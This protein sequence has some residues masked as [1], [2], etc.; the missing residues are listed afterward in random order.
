MKIAVTGANSNV[1]INFLTEISSNESIQITAGVRSKSAIKLLPES[2][3]IHPTIIDYNDSASLEKGI[4]GVDCVV[5]L[6]GI[7]I[8]GKHTKYQQANVDATAA[9]VAAVKT[10]N[11]A[12]LIFI[13]VIGADQNSKNEYF[14]SKGLA[15]KAIQDSNLSA[16]I[17]RT[18]I[19]L[20]PNTAGGSSLL[21][22]ARPEK[23]K[24]LGGGYYKM[25]PLDID[26]LNTAIINC[27]E[28]SLPGCKT[29]ELVGPEAISYRDLVSRVASMQGHAVKI[30]TIPIG[31]T[32]LMAK[33]TSFIK[34]G[35]F[36]P[37]VIDVITQDEEVAQN[38]DVE[39]GLN[40]TSLET[41]L[42]KLLEQ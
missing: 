39:L 28:K 33:L 21:N 11:L 22:T 27:A 8:E 9:V 25:R 42:K 3:N 36:T 5:H 12:H 26:D 17:L 20:G 7:L 30:G 14:R 19:L 24:L 1:G 37:A 38:A 40:L 15:E 18:P 35:G 4:E 32:K 23:T 34:G 29:Y 41:T 16:S 10:H 31:V 6:A 13:S 2:S